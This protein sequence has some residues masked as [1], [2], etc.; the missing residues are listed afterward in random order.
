MEKLFFRIKN[1]RYY[2]K[3]EEFINHIEKIYPRKI[4][5]N[6]DNLGKSLIELSIGRHFDWYIQKIVKKLSETSAFYWITINPPPNSVKNFREMEKIMTNFIN[7]KYVKNYEYN[8][9]QRNKLCIH[10][11]DITYNGIHVHLLLEKSV[12]PSKIKS[13]L[14][15]IFKKY[16]VK[17]PPF[18]DYTFQKFQK[19]LNQIHADKRNYLRGFKGNNDKLQMIDNDE[20]IRNYEGLPRLYTSFSTTCQ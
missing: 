10:S 19:N 3:N 1:K 7:L 20:T 15:R 14:F 12:K 18:N 17:L 11:D 16:R 13:D 5:E 6:K 2:T 9:E 8:I 4:T